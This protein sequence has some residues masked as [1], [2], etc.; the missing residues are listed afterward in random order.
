VASPKFHD[1][2]VNVNA[3]THERFT[4]VLTN[5]Q[6]DGTINLQDVYAYLGAQLADTPLKGLVN[7]SLPPKY[8]SITVVDAQ[9]M[10]VAH[11]VWIWLG[12][13]VPLSLLVGILSLAGAL[14]WSPRRRRTLIQASVAVGL[15]LIVAA[16]AM[17]VARDVRLGQIHDSTY[18]AASN[19]VWHALLSPL[20]TQTVVWLVVVVLILLGAWLTGPY[21]AAVRVRGSLSRF[22]SSVSKASGNLGA[23]TPAIAWLDRNLRTVEVVLLVLDVVVLMFL[24]PLTVAIVG[25]SV[26]ILII[27]VA[28]AEILASGAR[29]NAD[30]EGGKH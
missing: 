7:T 20:F 5:Y 15:S 21:R 6:G 27:L 23:E 29:A 1:V 11:N 22:A 17:R 10:P 14:L 16:V 2:W 8:G 24:T 3:R 4:E 25:W 9:W 19:T 12:W 30:V 18:H 26:L 13:L 28:L